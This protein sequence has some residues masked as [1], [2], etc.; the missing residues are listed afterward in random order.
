MGEQDG[1]EPEGAAAVRVGEAC[2]LAVSPDVSELS[3]SKRQPAP[4]GSLAG[5]LELDLPEC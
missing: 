1:L 3:S 4:P 5:F 2:C